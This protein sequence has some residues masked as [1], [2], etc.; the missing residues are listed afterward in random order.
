MKKNTF[1]TGKQSSGKTTK[2]KEITEGK[3]T[4]WY[5]NFKNL[6]YLREDLTEQT[7]FIVI[8]NIQ[9][10]QALKTIAETLTQK[11]QLT[12]RQ[13]YSTQKTT[14]KTPTIILITNSIS[15]EEAYTILSTT[16]DYTQL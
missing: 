8:D 6:R 9:N 10:T 5:S 11:E 4:I 7:K 2:A 3:E 14:I 12:F 15:K 13:L 1:I 16:F